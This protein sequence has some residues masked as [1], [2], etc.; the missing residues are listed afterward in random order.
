MNHH[1]TY[2][3]IISRHGGRTWAEAEPDK[4]AILYFSIP[5][6]VTGIIPIIK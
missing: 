6:Q 3:R 5:K 2:R 4:R 1:F